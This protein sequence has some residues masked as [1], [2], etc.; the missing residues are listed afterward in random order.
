MQMLRMQANVSKKSSKMMGLVD[1]SSSQN[2]TRSEL[3][4]S[5]LS[6][7]TAT[8]VLD[9]KLHSRSTAILVPD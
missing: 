8:E 5:N 6:Y 1:R 4:A 7:A 3:N 9:M 2:K